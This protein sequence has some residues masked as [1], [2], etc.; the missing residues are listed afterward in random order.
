MLKK[1]RI[2]GK[3]EQV[4]GFISDWYN[5]D[6]PYFSSDEYRNSNSPI[7]RRNYT[8]FSWL[9]GV[10]SSSKKV[11]K[12]S[13]PRGIPENCS[14]SIKAEVVGY[15]SDGH[16]HS[17]V[18]I[19]ELMNGLDKVVH[20]QGVVGFG[21]YKQFLERGSPDSWSSSVG[22]SISIC[23]A[24][25]MELLLSWGETWAE[26]HYTIISWEKT[27]RESLSNFVEKSLPQLIERCDSIDYNDVRIVFWFD[28]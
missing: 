4:K 19:D 5:T 14:N 6:I 13:D 22:G 24:D 10:R 27:I 15:G 18:S 25:E 9:A 8:L 3:W 21:Q 26:N 28:N 2:N 16:S 7:D 23:T 11:T 17:W 20:Y 12:I 1:K